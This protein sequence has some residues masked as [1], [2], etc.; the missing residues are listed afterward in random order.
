MKLAYIAFVVLLITLFGCKPVDDEAVEKKPSMVYLSIAW[1]QAADTESINEDEVD[2]EDRVH[3]LALLVFDSSTGEKIVEYF[4]ENISITEKQKLFIVEL[5]PG[6]RDFYFVANMPMAQLKAINNRT[7]MNTYL[8]AFRYLDIDLYSGASLTKGFPMSRVYTN[9]TINKAEGSFY[10][11]APFMPDGEE[12]IKLIRVL[13]KLEIDVTNFGLTI[14]DISYHNAYRKYSLRH[15]SPLVLDPPVYYGD[16]LL[17]EKEDKTYIFYMPEVVFSVPPVWGTGDHRP[18]NYFLIKASSGI[19]FEV[20]VIT[21]DLIPTANYMEFA[22]GQ[23]A[24]KPDY[25][26]YRN[27]HYRYLIRGLQTIEILY[28]VLP[29]DLVKKSAY[30]GYWFNVEVD[31][32]TVTI[33]NTEKTC[34]PHEVK[35]KTL[36]PYT[37]S[38]GTTEKMFNALDF[39]ASVSFELNNVPLGNYLEVYYNG[40][41]VKVFSN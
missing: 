7:D 16:T 30:M 15:T 23:L 38:D 2:Y 39:D 19:E 35:L 22:K 32:T 24:D 31:G 8:D 17:N 13:A 28:N 20:P 21:N 11:P 33:N 34:P 25:Q 29:W 14:Q 27:H 37:F 12:N 1:A 10:M 3:D 5:T 4:D 9:Q 41:L 18:V 40:V 36:Y 6:Q 26:I